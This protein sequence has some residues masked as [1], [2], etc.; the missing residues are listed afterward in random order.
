[1]T[2]PGCSRAGIAS[3]GGG[4]PDGVP[5]ELVDRRNPRACSCAPSRAPIWAPKLRVLAT[6][7]RQKRRPLVVGQFQRAVEQFFSLL[8]WR[9]HKSR[10]FPFIVAS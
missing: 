2:E 3:A 10:P 6:G 5:P 7:L 8:Q 4:V 9:F 1:M